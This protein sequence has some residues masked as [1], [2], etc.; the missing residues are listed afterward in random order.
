MVSCVVTDSHI[1]SEHQLFLLAAVA[2]IW[3]LR[4]EIKREK[5]RRLIG[6]EESAILF[7]LLSVDLFTDWSAVST[8]CLPLAIP[9]SPN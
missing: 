2:L 6:I 5:P 4:N 9:T 7:D 3:N 8:T 1:E